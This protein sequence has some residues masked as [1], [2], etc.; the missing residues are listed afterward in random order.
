MVK[1]SNGYK[2]RHTRSIFKKTARKKGAVRSLKYLLLRDQYVPGTKVDI[3]IDPSQQKGQPFYRYHG[4]TG[5][6]VGQRGDA[7]IINVKT[8]NKLRTLI[9]RP[10]HFK[11]Q[12]S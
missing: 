3:I 4:R 7:Y 10:E 5:T 1:Q 12:K 2:S 11:L 9:I 6:I 8:G